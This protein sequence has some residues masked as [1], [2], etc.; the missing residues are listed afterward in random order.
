MVEELRFGTGESV[1]QT[2]SA[3]KVKPH[4]VAF[5]VDESDRSWV[6]RPTNAPMVT[7]FDVFD[8]RGR[9]LATATA[10]FK[11]SPYWHTSF[12]AT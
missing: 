4:I 9:F 3:A 8:Q 12:A 2:F 7:V 10:P 5:D 11:V 1:S 6:R